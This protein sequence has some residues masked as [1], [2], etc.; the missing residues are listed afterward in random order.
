V[1]GAGLGGEPL[2]FL[3]RTDPLTV[4]Q[5]RGCAVV[6]AIPGGALAV[7]RAV[8]RR[9]RRNGTSGPVV[10]AGSGAIVESTREVPVP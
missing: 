7:T 8:A 1:L 3:L 9:T 5:L 6:A 2:R 10:P 4:G